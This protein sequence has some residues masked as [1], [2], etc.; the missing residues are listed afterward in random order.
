MQPN[1]LSECDGSTLKPPWRDFAGLVLLR[2]A[3]L[4][5]RGEN[6]GI[7]VVVPPSPSQDGICIGKVSHQGSSWGG[8]QDELSLEKKKK[9]PTRK[10]RETE[11]FS[12][13]T[14][15]KT[16]FYNFSSELGSAVGNVLFLPPARL[17]VTLTGLRPSLRLLATASL[18][19]AAGPR[20]PS[21]QG[22]RRQLSV[23]WLLQDLETGDTLDIF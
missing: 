23:S 14:V 1:P 8:A 2:C 11:P 9:K 12:R 6:A 16:A 21:Q 15:D 4:W 7:H 20:H 3:L 5:W 10:C 17:V 18:T 19:R 13:N 22:A